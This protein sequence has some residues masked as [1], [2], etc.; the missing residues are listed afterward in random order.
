MWE[1]S[2]GVLI[3][4]RERNVGR[5]ISRCRCIEVS[6]YDIFRENEVVYIV[7]FRV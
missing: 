4:R 3:S 5:G 2:R 6:S 1:F 7:E